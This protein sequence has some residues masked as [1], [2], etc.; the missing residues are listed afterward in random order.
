MLSCVY[1]NSSLSTDWNSINSCQVKVRA[2]KQSAK[3]V[4]NLAHMI[5][6][7]G[8]AKIFNYKFY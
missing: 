2:V 4:Q 3:I 5:N 6:K 8:H 1:K 7:T